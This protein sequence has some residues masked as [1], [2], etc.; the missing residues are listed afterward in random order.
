[1]IY[2]DLYNTY[3]GYGCAYLYGAFLLLQRMLLVWLIATTVEPAAERQTNAHNQWQLWGMSILNAAGLLFLLLA[4]PFNERFENLVQVRIRT[5]PSDQHHYSPRTIWLLDTILTSTVL[6]VAVSRLPLISAS[7][8][9]HR[10][11]VVVANQGLYFVALALEG[12]D[13][14]DP[15]NLGPMLNLFNLLALAMVMLA[16]FKTQALCTHLV[17]P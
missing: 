9:F 6:L 15:A 12:Q 2:K 16:A 13:A 11:V 4:A 3:S 8:L 1:M 10:Q 14:V 7:T 17:Q 5:K